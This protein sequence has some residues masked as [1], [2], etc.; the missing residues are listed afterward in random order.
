MLVTFHE[1]LEI[2]SQHNALETSGNI[3]VTM[4]IVIYSYSHCEGSQ[5]VSTAR[6]LAGE[7]RREMSG[8][9]QLLISMLQ[10]NVGYCLVLP[11]KLGVFT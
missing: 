1:L 10:I 2:T 3:Q 5:I 7:L 11:T 4:A 8:H 9:L 6:V